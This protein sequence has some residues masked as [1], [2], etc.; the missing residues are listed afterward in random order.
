[1]I[2]RKSATGLPQGPELFFRY[3][4]DL[5][6]LLDNY[7]FVSDLPP[8]SVP[9]HGYQHKLYASEA[10]LLISNTYEAIHVQII[11]YLISG[12]P[13]LDLRSQ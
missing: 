13:W 3:Y 12:V 8:E 4:R 2:V 5:L 9:I 7:A 1:M 11:V 6:F 10:V